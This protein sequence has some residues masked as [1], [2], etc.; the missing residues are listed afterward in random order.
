VL[1]QLNCQSAIALNLKMK[2]KAKAILL[3]AMLVAASTALIVNV[4]A[5][6]PTGPSVDPKGL[7]ISD[8]TVLLKL[9]PRVLTQT[10][11]AT[12]AAEQARLAIRL[13]RESADPRFLGQAQTLLQPWW[14]QQNAPIELAILQA[15]IQQARHQFIDSKK[16][17]EIVLKRDPNQAQAWL[18]LASLEKLTGSFANAQTS[19]AQLERLQLQLY[20]GACRFEIFSLIGKFQEA[21]TGFSAL[22]A[23]SSA[24]D[25]NLADRAWLHSLAAENEERAGRGPEA[26]LQ[27]QKSLRL[28]SDLYTQI[29]YSDWL[30]RNDQ[31]DLA[32][33]LLA[34]MPA[35][36]AVLLRQAFAYKRKGS[37]DWKFVASEFESRMKAADQRGDSQ[38][39]HSRERGLF[40]LWILEDYPQAETFASMNLAEQREGI[41]WYLSLSAAQ[42]SGNTAV[43][44]RVQRQLQ[45]NGMQDARLNQWLKNGS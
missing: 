14:S 37:N 7:P 27:Y 12:Q 15:I 3:A 17:L 1:K 11:S 35:S 2:S 24:R 10:S 36:D 31:L 43:L 25:Q 29:A 39:A 34:T 16:T 5:V 20:S 44:M 33:S 41:D 9:A 18:T 42:R 13:A 38:V 32:L 8:G 26:Q 40:A 21:R 22:L 6:V 19:C 23:Q 4:K 45:E 28:Q 30:I